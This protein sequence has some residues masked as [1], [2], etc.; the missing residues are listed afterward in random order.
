MS[1]KN[2]FY[3]PIRRYR[4][5]FPIFMGKEKIGLFLDSLPHVGGEGAGMGV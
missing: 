4:G 3:A 1:I 5:T 2:N